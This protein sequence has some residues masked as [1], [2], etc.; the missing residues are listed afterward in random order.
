MVRFRDLKIRS[1]LILVFIAIAFVPLMVVAALSIWSLKSSVYKESVNQLISIRKI[2]KKQIEEYFN[3]AYMEM[4][5][6]AR[7]EDVKGLYDELLWYHV[8]TKAKNDGPYNVS[9]GKYQRIRAKWGKTFTQFMGD[10]GFENL[11]IVCKNHGHVMFSGTKGS[12]LGTNLR[13]GPYKDSPLSKLWHNVV[14]NQDSS[15]V[16][17]EPY[18]PF[19]NGPASFMG[20][21]LYR[22]KEMVG[23]F[24]LQV[25]VNAVNKIMT[26]RSGLGKTGETYLV[27]LDKK[28]RSD[29]FID[30]KHH[31]VKASFEN[32]E[33]GSVDTEAFREA[34]S[35]KTLEK[36]MVNYN[37]RRVLSAITMVDLGMGF[38]WA[39]FADIGEDEINGPVNKIILSILIFGILIFA[40][41]ILLGFFAS[42]QFSGPFREAAAVLNKISNGDLTSKIEARSQDE[43]GLMV[44]SLSGMLS[45]IAYIVG[46]VRI[47]GQSLLNG[48][49]AVNSTAQSLSQ[50]S[51]EQAANV[52]ETSSSLEEMGQVIGQNSDNARVTDDMASKSSREM[53]EGGQAMKETLAAM[54][55]ISE[56]IS[57]IEEIA[58]QTNLLALNAAIE[59]AR[60]G[61]HG[62]GFAM[63]AS[64]VRKLAERSQVAAKEISNLAISSVG[65][66][67]KTGELIEGIVPNIKKTA[68]L[69]QEIFAA[70]SEQSAGAQQ[71]NKGMA[72]LD[73]ITQA[74]ATASEELAATAEELTGQA[75]QLKDIMEYFKITPG[76]N[77]EES[78]K[79]K[80]EKAANAK[81][82]PILPP[83]EKEKNVKS[84]EALEPQNGRVSVQLRREASIPREGSSRLRSIQTADVLTGLEYQAQS[85]QVTDGTPKTPAADSLS[86]ENSDKRPKEDFAKNYEDDFETF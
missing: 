57:I 10:A 67:E 83:G 32:P 52:E 62:K 36:F 51:N 23:V 49:N 29:S 47:N 26:K 21:P 4:E 78:V 7:S 86:G 84:N 18:E 58:Y 2:K 27:G 9:T 39:L 73:S 77:Q 53:A 48:A 41:V 40:I 35:G 1:K 22:G 6:F 44:G 66:A 76:E 72:L 17:F 19:N 31:S 61:E 45:K 13:Y 25:S 65:I 20:I 12:D 37:G 82:E 80:K 64:E 3:K 11:F 15:M 8:D 43:I 59:A 75:T 56:K 28:M 55:N 68:D 33:K 50:G 16:D 74:N 42:S 70:S 79:P 63:V 30:P 24:I 54:K 46:E 5:V 38:K 85:Y 69:V 60:A 14:A 81:T 34:F 71:I